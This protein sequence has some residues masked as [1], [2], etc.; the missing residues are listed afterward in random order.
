MK[1]KFIVLVILTLFILACE[2]DPTAP[3]KVLV[4]PSNLVL[5][6]L[7]EHN[8]KLS[9]DDNNEHDS[10]FR[11]DRR[12]G[13]AEWELNYRILEDS[14]TTM[15]DSSLVEMTNYS[16]RVYTVYGE[17]T[18]G[19]T[20]AS[21]LYSYNY[22]ESITIEDYIY[23][24]ANNSQDIQFSL[25][26][27]S[28]NPL[29]GE[30]QVWIKLLSFPNGTNIN[31]ELFSEADSLMITSLNGA[32]LLTVNSGEDGGGIELQVYTKNFRNE[33]ISASATG[34]ILPLNLDVVTLEFSNLDP[35]TID[36]CGT[37][38]DESAEIGVNLLTEGGNLV[39]YDY[40][41]YFELEDSPYGTSI[42]GT[43]STDISISSDEGVASIA[44]SSG[45]YSG[46]VT[47]QVYVLNNADEIIGVMREDINVLAG[48]VEQAEFTFEGVNEAE[49]MGDGKWKIEVAIL[50]TDEYNNPANE[51]TPVY[52]SIQGSPDW[53]VIDSMDIFVGNISEDYHQIQGVAF[54]SIVYDGLYT[55]E[56]F[57]VNVKVENGT[58]WDF[59]ESEQ[60]L[61]PIQQ[62]MLNVMLPE[63]VIEWNENDPDEVVIEFICSVIDGQTNPIN[64][65]I[66]FFDSQA[67]Q[68]LEPDPADTG[69]PYT[70]LTTI[71]DGQSGVLVKEF[72]LMKYECPPPE[73]G[74]PGTFTADLTAKIL[75]TNCEATATVTLIRNN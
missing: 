4:A 10:G 27:N 61:L 14:V 16:Y 12:V 63:T 11:V 70:G 25:H 73:N 57:T 75:G 15:V 47:L 9:W 17:E 3:E 39:D 13:E 55:N 7:G 74:E 67:G 46:E 48:P 60:F 66:L 53:A 56:E 31:N 36:V 20:E 68:P 49:N 29:E 35:I 45:Q 50:L 6:Q 58:N 38:G 44:I 51:G 65:Q 43:G 69:D 40:M 2:E 71:V 1:F 26:D 42:N 64:N 18:S 8:I 23:L 19:F 32:G 21:M 34:N 5:Q 24:N 41:V 52:T 54:T 72:R 62:P 37:G 22:L 59:T 33:V 28:N 30:Y